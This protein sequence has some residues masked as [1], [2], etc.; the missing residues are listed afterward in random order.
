MFALFAVATL[1][2]ATA[3]RAEDA[4]PAAAKPP[5]VSASAPT[6]AVGT[7]KGA[8][9]VDRVVTGALTSVPPA[10]AFK[11][12]IDLVNWYEERGGV[13]FPSGD[14]IVYCHGFGCEFRTAIPID[15]ADKAELAAIFAKH[16]DS[17]KAEREGIDLAVQWWEKKAAPLLG[18]KPDIRGSEYWQAHQRG[19]TDCLDEATN[20]TT[21]LIYLQRQGLLRYHHVMRPDSRGGFFYAHA[22][23]VFHEKGGEDWV[24][25]SWM[26]DSGDPND[27]MTWAEWSSHW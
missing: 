9:P 17:A 16:Q 15:D 23:A 20:S 13:T 6:H 19:Q 24:V 14:R 21:I 1:Q 7:K 10:I 18:G 3:A 11:P 22:T 27:V 25:D 2:L 5:V 26:R 4:P 8:K 12:S